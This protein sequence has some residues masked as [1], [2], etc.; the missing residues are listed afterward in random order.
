MKVFVLMLLLLLGPR[1]L[2]VTTSTKSWCLPYHC[3]SYQVQQR[4]K[5]VNG[6]AE[7]SGC[8]CVALGTCSKQHGNQAS[9]SNLNNC[10]SEHTSS[11]ADLMHPP[12]AALKP[13]PYSE[14]IHIVGTE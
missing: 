5:V 14:H 10:C 13:D 7:L 6:L 11:R 3:C 8:D 1:R 2:Q 9:R 4:G 12:I